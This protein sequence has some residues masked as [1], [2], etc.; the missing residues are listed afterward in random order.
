MP[1]QGVSDCGLSLSEFRGRNAQILHF[2][3]P[4]QEAHRLKCLGVFEGQLIQ[5]QKAGN[6]MILM[7]AGGRVAIA[8]DVANGIMV[9]A[10]DEQAA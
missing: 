6:P 1:S 7:A 8:R 2:D 5:L 10:R 9:Q 4:E 3:L